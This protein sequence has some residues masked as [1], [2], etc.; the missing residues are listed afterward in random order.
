MAAKLACLAPIMPDT[1]PKEESEP[2]RKNAELKP[3]KSRII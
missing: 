2:V 3:K 1:N